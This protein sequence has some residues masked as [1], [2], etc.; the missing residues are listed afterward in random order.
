M[1]WFSTT[2]SSSLGKKLLMALTGLFLIVF[3]IGHLAG[4]M[5]LFF[6]HQD[7]GLAFN[8][9]AKF[10]TTN[11]AVKILSYVTYIS[12]LAHVVYSIVLSRK[13]KSARPVGYSVSTKDS[14]STTASRNMGVLGTI[15]LLFIVIH[16]KAFWYEMHWG[17]IGNDANG[18]RDLYSIVSA[19]YAELWYVAIYVVAMFFL[20]MHLSHGF[21][22]AFQTLGINHKKYTPIIN[23]IGKAFAIIV[24][25]LFAMMP[26]WMYIKNLG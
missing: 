4:N 17:V 6:A 26:I 13:N 25:L 18:N 15:L 3:L 21:S 10:M 16:L 19:A 11:P 5:Q 12:I 8:I 24:P 23:G 22:S 9:Y 7:N 20:A 14:Q 2:L 1:S